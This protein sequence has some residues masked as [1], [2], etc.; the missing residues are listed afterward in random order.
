MIALFGV[1]KY[2]FDTALPW[3]FHVFESFQKHAET[4][5]QLDVPYCGAIS[6]CSP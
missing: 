5:E 3:Y 2:F 6:T 1:N 4:R